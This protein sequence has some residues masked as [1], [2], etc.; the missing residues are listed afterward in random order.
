M[1]ST[2]AGSRS[3]LDD[4]REAAE[5]QRIAVA[6]RRFAV[7]EHASRKTQLEARVSRAEALLRMSALDETRTRVLA[8]FG[9]RITAVAVA[10]GDRVRAGDVLLSMY[11]VAQ[12]EI[13]AQLPA[14]LLA[15]IR[16]AM[17]AGETLA[18]SSEVDGRTVA[19]RLDRLAAL[20]ERGSG[21]VDGLFTVGGDA[22]RLAIGRTL[23][24][25]LELPAEDDVV[26]LPLEALYGSDRVF[27]LDGDRMREVAVQ[28]VGER[29]GADGEVRV[30]VRSPALVEGVQVITT[31]LPNAIDGLRVK[32]AEGEPPAS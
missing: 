20:V 29:R 2:R 23:E 24:L 11:D 30:L 31:Q 19:A 22:D 14:R 27:L 16:T 28:R 10:P 17:D 21:G 25:R 7:R 9:G 13:R 4:A 26:A 32:L 5:R 18:A 8:P 12:V 3:Q 6:E 1:S 15:Q